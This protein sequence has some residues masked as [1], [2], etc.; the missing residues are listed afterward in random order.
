MWPDY[1]DLVGFL[2]TGELQD[3]AQCCIKWGGNEGNSRPLACSFL[4]QH[5]I[6]VLCKPPVLWEHARSA[7]EAESSTTLIPLHHHVPSQEW[8]PH[9]SNYSQKSHSRL[10]LWGLR[11]TGV[12]GAR[13]VRAHTGQVGNWAWAFAPQP[14]PSHSQPGSHLTRSPGLY[15]AIQ[16]LLHWTSPL[17]FSFPI[18]IPKPWYRFLGRPWP[19]RQQ[20]PPANPRVHNNGACNVPYTFFYICIPMFKKWNKDE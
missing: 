15:S 16:W 8:L 7:P 1:S 4:T 11:P 14:G 5:V 19:L 10:Q 9:L 18:K 12:D 13:V 2:L 17:A 3:S 20:A 6:L